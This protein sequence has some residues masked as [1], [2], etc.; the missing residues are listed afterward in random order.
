MAVSAAG[1]SNSLVMCSSNI[2]DDGNQLW[3]KII[4]HFDS[5]G[6][7]TMTLRGS[8]I[9][10]Q[11]IQRPILESEEGRQERAEMAA[12]DR[13]RLGGNV[14]SR[15]LLMVPESGDIHQR[16][17]EISAYRLLLHLDDSPQDWILSMGRCF[18]D[19]MRN[20]YGP[21]TVDQQICESSDTVSVFSGVTA[22]S[23]D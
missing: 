15:H 9:S 7:V 22:L 5:D 3:T 8:E 20:T 2:P 6:C 14:V 12:A 13:E 21:K 18:Q 23:N 11:P 1:H 16:L 10:N 4:V 17:A 19:V